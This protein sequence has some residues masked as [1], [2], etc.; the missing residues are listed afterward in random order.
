MS[1]A[2]PGVHCGVELSLL[3]ETWPAMAASRPAGGAAA[4]LLGVRRV[5]G[6]LAEGCR[7]SEAEVGERH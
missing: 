2:A 3:T 7:G 4:T 5:Q 1:P 6:E